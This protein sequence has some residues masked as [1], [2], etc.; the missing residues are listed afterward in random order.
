MSYYRNK[1]DYK[2]RQQTITWIIVFV[3]IIYISRL[4][5]L[6]IV[7]ASYKD[8]ADSNAFLKKTIYPSRGLIY[9]RNGKLIVSNQP[10]YD[11]MLIMRE[12]HDFD[13]LTFCNTLNITKEE[14]IT[15]INEIKDRKKNP[16]YSRYTPQVFMSQLSGEDYGR[17]Q[18]KQ[19]R[20]S[21]TFVQQRVLR[22][23]TVPHGAHAIGS[24]GEVNQK[25]IESD[26]YYKK[27]DYK[28]QSGIEKTYEEQLRGEKGVEILLRDVHG[29]IKGRYQNGERD[30]LPKSGKNVTVGLDIEL[31]Q[32]GEEL[33]KYKLGSIVA[34]EP[35]TGEIL[36]L[37]SSPSFD[38]SL[39]VGRKRSVNYSELLKD[40]NKPLFD[41]PM[42]AMYP[43]GST[44]KLV[45]ALVMQQE[46]LINYNTTF[47]CHGGYF[48]GGGRKLGCHAHSSPLNL[49]Q[50][51]QNSCNA[52][53]CFCLREMLDNNLAKYKTSSHAYDVWRGHV[54]SLGF[55]DKLGVD[56]PNEKSG[57][58][59][60]S[61]RYDKI[62][63]KN[64]WRSSTIISI[65]IGQGEVLATP[66]QTANLAAC[67]ANK[68]YFYTPHIMKSIEGDSIDIK[69]RTKHYSTIESKY[70][71]V[72]HEG[73]LGAVMAG[74]ARIGRI[75][76]LEFCGKTGTAQNPHGKD[77][78]IFI[79]FAPKDNPK[80]AIAVYVENA[81]FGATWAVPIASLMIEKY[82][83]RSISPNRL[84]LEERIMNAKFYGDTT[85]NE[86]ESKPD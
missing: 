74:T 66:I 2:K 26:S 25:Q 37:V 19:F 36:A 41:R 63:G 59:L 30:I 65:S 75:D 81:G 14:F 18:E 62:Y 7:D 79:A 73:M 16:G 85:E 67:I 51:I 4:F 72:V 22:E 34:I 57:L 68:G 23:Y 53:Y 54:T 15:R 77:H 33:M 69:Y 47:P 10:V 6:Q 3:A 58:I 56:F 55:G 76:S 64:H 35:S 17:F 84:Y 86:T 5:F 71:D 42:M 9:D 11:V 29:R 38:P 31:Q 46:E 83:R 13:T 24:I 27:G 12:M 48:Y 40:P 45:Q 50:S 8:N 61:S 39:L 70:F 21:G 32:Y 52:Y 82:L 44:F 43:P 28:G 1:Q 20:F 60:K 80:I 78:S 49:P